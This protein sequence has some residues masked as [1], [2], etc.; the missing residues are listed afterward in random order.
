ML[1]DYDVRWR[2]TTL[3]GHIESVYVVGVKIMQFGWPLIQ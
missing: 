1:K 3:Q 2:Q